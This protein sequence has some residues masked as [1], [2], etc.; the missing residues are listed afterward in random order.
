MCGDSTRITTIAP[1]SNPAVF[2]SSFAGTGVDSV[3]GPFT[4][5]NSSGTLTGIPKFSQSSRRRWAV[6]LSKNVVFG[7][8]GLR[9]AFRF[10]CGQVFH[11]PE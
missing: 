2:D 9:K 4:T 8:A 11:M 7:L 5:I 6:R 10:V 3:S 1:T